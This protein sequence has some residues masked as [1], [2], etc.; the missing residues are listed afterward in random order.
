M[1]KAAVWMVALALAAAGQRSVAAGPQER[2]AAEA[3]R[4]GA[5]RVELFESLPAEALLE[6]GSRQPAESYTEPAFGFVRV[7]TRY[8]RNALPLDRA[9]PFVLRATLERPLAA[10]EWEVRL[11]ARGAARLLVDGQ[12]LLTTQ[13]QKPN[14][15]A[16]DHVPAAAERTGLPIRPLPAPHQEQ[17][18]ALRLDGSPHRFTLVAVVGGKGLYPSPGELSV[19]IARPGTMPRLLGADDAPPLTDAGWEAYAAAA[20]ARHL[21]SDA[22]RRRRVSAPVVEEWRERHRQVG[23]W[24]KRQPSPAE[25]PARPGWPSRTPIDRFLTARMGSLK[26]TAPLSDL[27]FLRRVSLDTV[28]VTP[29]LVEIRRFLADPPASR[30][31]RV[32]DRYLADPGW[33][34]HWLAYWQDVLAEN[35]GILKPDLNNSGPFRWWL[36]QALAEGYPF[37]RILT[38]LIEM[39]GSSYQGAPAGFAQATLN[40][41]PMAAKADILAQ[42]FLGQ[43]LSCA[44]CHDAPA[45]PFKQRDL[46]SVAAML[47]GKAVSIPKTSTVPFIAGFRKPL[48]QVTTHP[49]EP[50]DPAWPFPELADASPVSVPAGSAVDSGAL[51][52]RRKLAALIVSPANWRFAE[53]VANRV[54]KRYVGRGLV[55]PV[56][57]W[58]RARPSHPEL[59]RYLAREFVASGY[60]LKHVARLVLTSDLYQRHALPAPPAET[61]LSERRFTGPYRRRLSAEQVVDSLYRVVGKRFA[62]EELNLSPLGDK[63]PNEF[64]NLGLP[65]R[66]WEFTAP[67]NERDRPA[68]ALP[69]TQSIVD[70][71]STFGWR[72]A[73]QNPISAREENASPMQT[74]I[75]ANGVVGARIVRL[76]DDSAITELCMEERTLPTLVRELFLRVLSR[77]PSERESRAFQ[78]YLRPAFAGRRVPGAERQASTFHTDRRVS[79]ANHLNSEATMIRMEEERRLRLGDVPTRRLR[80]AFRER[81]EDALWALVNTPEFV[82]VP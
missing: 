55:E 73:R 48:V 5:V 31:E 67:S 72:Q 37:D 63:G 28:G 47:T 27:E 12:A 42:A 13:P 8:T 81:L 44:R 14:G 56:D 62:S 4:D 69:I 39:E 18:A 30:R 6:P 60:D 54:W 21:A 46:F 53:V 29:S 57:D 22:E 59:L 16:H 79:W 33:A 17:V 66:A 80:P 74:L 24:L 65:C 41:A 51:R 1:A 9:V 49:G 11:R 64:L 35:P 34:D 32:I 50:I 58:S 15:S 26:P 78:A 40:D 19:S 82:L 20:V 61:S 45:H 25:P 52:T 23:E 10:G 71:L 77:P 36:R 2:S 38:E 7:P 43:N 3:T 76:S 75:L 68:L 70:V